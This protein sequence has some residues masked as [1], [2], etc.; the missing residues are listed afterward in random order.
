M[1]GVKGRSGGQNAKTVEDHKLGGTFRGHRHAGVINPDPPKGVPQPPKA[2]S[3]DAAAEWDRMITRLQE[4]LPTTRGDRVLLEQVL[5]N[6]LVNSLQ[7]MQSQQP[8]LRV[9]ELETQS[10][11]A[12]V[13]LRVSDHGPG[14]PEGIAD[15][16]FKSFVTTKEEG[17]G[18]GLSICRTIVESHGGRLSFANQPQGGAMFTIQLP[19]EVTTSPK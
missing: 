11:Q 7:A 19:C 3:G 8:A 1:A 4:P 12:W 13:C 10:T 17:L 2:L 6:L 15:Q 9:I 5:V 16:L 14:I 18:I